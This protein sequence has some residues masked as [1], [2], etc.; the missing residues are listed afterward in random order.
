MLNT[1][2][3]RIGQTYNYYYFANRIRLFAINKKCNCTIV[4]LD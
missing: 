2:Q 4:D 1:N 3:F